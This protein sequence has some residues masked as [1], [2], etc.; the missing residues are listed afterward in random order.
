M[1][2]T[3]RIL[4]CSKRDEDLPNESTSGVQCQNT[5]FGNMMHLQSSIC[6]KE[7][8]LSQQRLLDFLEIDPPM[9]ASY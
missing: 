5:I 8:G 4:A 6:R 1:A 7:T 9:T 2:T 3:K